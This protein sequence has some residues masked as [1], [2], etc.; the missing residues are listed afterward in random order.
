MERWSPEWRWAEADGANAKCDNKIGIDCDS[1]SFPFNRHPLRSQIEI[2][3]GSCFFTE[4]ANRNHDN[5]STLIG[6]KKT[7]FRFLFCFFRFALPNR[8][9]IALS[10]KQVLHSTL[11]F[12][13]EEI[14]AETCFSWHWCCLDYIYSIAPSKKAAFRKETWGVFIGFIDYCPVEIKS[15]N[16]LRAE[17][18]AWQTPGLQNFQ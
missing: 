18:L 5:V 4:R 11:L 17:I 6:K 15:L 1:H 2:F 12:F 13:C 9:Q 16:S 14:T 8:E 10:S 7:L 3:N